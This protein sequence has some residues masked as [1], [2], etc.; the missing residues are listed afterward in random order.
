MQEAAHDDATIDFFLKHS[1]AER[2]Y[3]EEVNEREVQL[4]TKEQRLMK[5][6]RLEMAVVEEEAASSCS[7]SGYARVAWFD[8]GYLR[9]WYWSKDIFFRRGSICCRL[10]RL[11]LDSLGIHASVG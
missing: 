3:E 10:K 6:S 5:L 1:L 4:A 9:L 2:Q 8:S 7:V 11:Q